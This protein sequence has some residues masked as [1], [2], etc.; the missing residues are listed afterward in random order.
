MKILIGSFVA[1]VLML[2]TAA[3]QHGD[4]VFIRS[5]NSRATVVAVPGDRVRIDDSGVYVNSAP[6]TWI[7]KELLLALPKPWAPEIIPTGHYFVAG[8]SRTEQAGNVSMSRHWA[9]TGAN[10]LESVR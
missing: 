10:N 3:Y 7:S 1:V 8:E 2:Q 5:E 4:L 9:L 6:V